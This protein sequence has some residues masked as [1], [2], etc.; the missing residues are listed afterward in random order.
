MYTYIHEEGREGEV[1]SET[2][3]GEDSTL[4]V[5]SLITPCCHVPHSPQIHLRIRSLQSPQFPPPLLPELVPY[6]HSMESHG[7]KDF[8]TPRQILQE[9][10]SEQQ[11]GDIS[12]PMSF[13]NASNLGGSADRR[14]SNQGRPGRFERASPST[15]S[16]ILEFT[17]QTQR[18]TQ[19][20]RTASRIRELEH[21]EQ[22]SSEGSP[23]AKI[24][25]GSGPISSPRQSDII[26]SIT[27]CT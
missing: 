1:E 4:R 12:T 27:R 26:E 16:S 5:L 14:S 13:V 6:G 20:Q 15:S 11:N 3:T 8:R 23:R 2:V 17:K 10:L 9:S 25:D 19:S 22:S 7:K 18:D 24:S 21:Q